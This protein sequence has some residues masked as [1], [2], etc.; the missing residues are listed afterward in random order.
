MVESSPRKHRRHALSAEGPDHVSVGEKEQAKCEPGTRLVD[1]DRSV[2][3]SERGGDS[4]G[5]RKTH[6][7]PPILDRSPD[8][9]IS[10]NKGSKGRQHRPQVE[11][12]ET[13]VPN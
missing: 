4:A 2:A 13:M 10:V 5:A 8:R 7:E 12:R 11:S 1:R 3:N 6:R 9:V